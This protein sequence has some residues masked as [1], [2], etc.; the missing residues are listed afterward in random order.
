MLLNEESY[1]SLMF[2]VFGAYKIFNQQICQ[3]KQDIFFWMPLLKIIKT[4]TE[5]LITGIYSLI[6]YYN[7]KKQFK[8]R[9]N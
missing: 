8:E 3:P 5:M 7:L 1:S 2:G 6:T 4:L 9:E